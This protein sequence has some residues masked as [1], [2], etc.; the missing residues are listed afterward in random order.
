MTSSTTPA[1]R[2]PPT[3]AERAPGEAIQCAVEIV[4]TCGD[5]VPEATE[6]LRAAVG[7]IMSIVPGA[8]RHDAERAMIE[9][10]LT[11]L[12]LCVE[13]GEDDRAGDRLRRAREQVERDF[14]T[15]N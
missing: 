4:A 3:D 8:V 2:S 1:H 14:P 13:G 10:F 7:L 15:R 5:V 11:R 9:E 12:A 6:H